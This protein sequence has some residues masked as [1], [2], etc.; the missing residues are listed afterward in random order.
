M[1]DFNSVVY[2]YQNK[3]VWLFEQAHASLYTAFGTSPEKYALIIVWSFARIGGKTQTSV[4]CFVWPFISLSRLSGDM[5]HSQDD[6]LR[7]G[8]HLLPAD[9]Y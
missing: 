7:M 4:N 3:D 8:G 5:A 1:V 9:F 6:R 2:T